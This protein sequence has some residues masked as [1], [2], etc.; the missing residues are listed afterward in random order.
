MILLIDIG[1]TT[2]DIGVFT[3]KKIIFLK[4]LKTHKNFQIS[5]K[6]IKKAIV[7]SVVP[8][9]TK[10]VISFLKKKRIQTFVI[11]KDLS[12]PLKSEYK[13]LLGQDRI[14]N[15]FGALKVVKKLPLAVIDLGT[16]ITLDFVDKRGV[17]KGG[18][19]Y[20][21]LRL[22]L[23]SLLERA[24]LL[25]DI[26][27]KE[28]KKPKKL[29]GAN[30]KETILSGL[31]LGARGVCELMIK[32]LKAKYP[33]LKTVLTGGDLKIANSW[34]FI[35]KIIPYLNLHSLRFIAEYYKIP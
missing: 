19:I 12:V 17:Y 10:E 11:G 26:K 18:I 4:K 34:E 14:L 25:K 5:T 3:K 23:E 2:T 28:I 13:G 6:N 20:P 31:F 27:I 16:A 35:D 29:I 21:G 8:P 33:Q 9:K 24:Y 30:S 15:C 32:R 1:N 22:S 7:C